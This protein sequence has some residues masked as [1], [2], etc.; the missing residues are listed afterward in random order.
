MSIK[1]DRFEVKEI[2][3]TS[4]NIKI[5]NPSTILI[6]DHETDNI[7]SYIQLTN[8]KMKNKEIADRIILAIEDWILEQENAT[9][10][11][12]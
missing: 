4:E 5:T 11:Q 12:H 2:K 1:I 9:E 7:V 6:K 8:D 10:N 3:K